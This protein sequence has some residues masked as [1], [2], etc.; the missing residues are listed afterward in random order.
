DDLLRQIAAADARPPRQIDD[1]V[2]R[3]LERICLR[4]LAKPASQRYPTARDLADDLR[5]FLIAPAPALP[6]AKAPAPPT[7]D[8]PFAPPTPPLTP[9]SDS[10]QRPAKVVPKG[11]RSF[12]AGDTDFF[13]DLLPGP[14]DRDGLPEGLRFWKAWAEQADPE[15]AAPVGLLYG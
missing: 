6:T 9:A 5:H 4:C 15:R 12:D 11:L 10:T 8:P 13:L 14:R 2:P 3:E 1:A 7:A